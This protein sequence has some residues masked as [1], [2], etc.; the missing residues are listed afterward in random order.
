M[1]ETNASDRRFNARMRTVQIVASALLAGLL[2]FL[3]IVPFLGPGQGQVRPPGAPIVS[4]TALVFLACVLPVWYFLPAQVARRQVRKI[5]EGTWT[6]A[7]ASSRYSQMAPNSGLPLAAFPTD[8]DKLLAVF[9]TTSLVG[10]SLLNGLGFL[11]C[12]AYLVEAEP[13][14]LGVVGVAVLLFLVTFPT[15]SRI[16]HWLGE[17]QARVKDIRQA[18]GLP[19][20]PSDPVDAEIHQLKERIAELSVFADWSFCLAAVGT[21][22]GSFCLLASLLWPRTQDGVEVGVFGIA[23]AGLTAVLVWRVFVI[24]RVNREGVAV[25]GE[26]TGAWGG[27]D[28]TICVKY[29]YEGKEIHTRFTWW[30]GA[31]SGS[32]LPQKG[33]RL[34]LVLDP[35]KPS[36]CYVQRRDGA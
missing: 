29:A 8:A 25:E 23:V 10:W 28:N 36:R 33:D 9:Q 5:A 1:H 34:P 30:Q 35:K 2:I 20:V 12:I 17:Q 15:R 27:R 16:S 4:Y 18:E 26:V 14:A 11:G 3:G 21:G 6:P 32:P 19:A 7:S 13:F 31:W 24:R 22:I